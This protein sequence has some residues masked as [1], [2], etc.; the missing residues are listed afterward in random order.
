MNISILGAT[1]SVGRQTLE[2]VSGLPDIKVKALAAGSD[3]IK[4]AEMAK[5]LR[6]EL[7]ALYDHKAALQLQK[8]LPDIKIAAG[9]EGLL[10]CATYPNVDL[11]VNAVVGS[12]GIRPTIAAL[13]S[14]KDVAL[15]NKE[16]LVAA[17]PLVM[18]A[19]K[20]HGKKIRT[21]DSEHSA[22]WQCL[23]GGN[24]KDVRRLILTASGGPFR[25][26]TEKE[27]C[28]A[29]A[30][31]ALRHPNW[32]MG[33]KITID[34]AT[35]MNKGLEYIEAHWLFDTPYEKIDVIIHPQSIIHSMVEF[36][37]G[38]VI[39]QMADPDMRQPIQYALT[40]PAHPARP[41]KPL[42]FSELKAL[43]FDV[44]DMQRFPCLGLAM[45]AGKIGGT[46]PAMMNT[47]NE[48]LVAAYLRREIKFYDISKIIEKA[49]V[50]YNVR[51]ITNI[52]DVEE[53]E[54][55][56]TQYYIATVCA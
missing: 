2:V 20:E 7:V 27:I 48:N 3:F 10:E 47:L 12:I 5:I 1:G 44:P 9:I 53:A 37:D 13:N 49:M 19:A 43:T 40:Y 17:G 55:W 22:I 35:M 28:E 42:D 16:T 46:M 34:C 31:D 32:I 21:M 29:T 54:S 14:G 50:T 18:A 33:P 52:E 41:H 8:L 38:A 39:A 51:P 23:Q 24:I 11:V 4:M 45:E 36:E 26:W 15:A 6:P 25:K 56:A 30:E